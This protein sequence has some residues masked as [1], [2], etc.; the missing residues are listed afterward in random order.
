VPKAPDLVQTLPPEQSMSSNAPDPYA[1][2]EAMQGEGS[3]QQALNPLEGADRLLKAGQQYAGRPVANAIIDLSQ[4]GP[5]RAPVEAVL[6]DQA[7][8]LLQRRALGC[9]VATSLKARAG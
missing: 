8:N 6:G 1:M 3:V 7:A 4:K 2:M 9:S 5:L